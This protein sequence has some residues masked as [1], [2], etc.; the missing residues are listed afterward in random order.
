M[1][2]IGVFAL[3]LLTPLANGAG[4]PILNLI[5]SIPMPNVKGRID[6]FA[7]DMKGH[8]L[9][10][11]ALGNDTLEVLDTARNRHEKSLSGF[12]EPQGLIYVPEM[13]RLYVA[14]GS[15]DR[16]DILDARSLT[17]VGRIDKLADADNV[18]Y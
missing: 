15:A 8:R 12:G 5:A 9:Y 10:V 4:E 6:H 18:R 14:S 2:L 3:S 17:S 13:Q 7:V 16:V 1:R 11:A